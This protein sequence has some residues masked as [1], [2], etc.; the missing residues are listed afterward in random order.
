MHILTL[1]F[2]P[3]CIGWSFKL[4]LHEFDNALCQ[5][6]TEL[7]TLLYS[8]PSI[9]NKQDVLSKHNTCTIG[10]QVILTVATIPLPF[11]FTLVNMWI[12]SHPCRYHDITFS[13]QYIPLSLSAT[14]YCHPLMFY[15]FSVFSEWHIPELLVGNVKFQSTYNAI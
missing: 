4:S 9:Q 2:W 6:A 15:E 10:V 3:H 7:L 13:E 5:S 12:A 14:E 8:H 1:P 11:S